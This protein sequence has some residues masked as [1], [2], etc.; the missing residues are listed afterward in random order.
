MYSWFYGLSLVD[1]SIDFSEFD[2]WWKSFTPSIE[3]DPT[4]IQ[5]VV[6]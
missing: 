3:Y 1:P 6:P 5:A 2:A 4:Y